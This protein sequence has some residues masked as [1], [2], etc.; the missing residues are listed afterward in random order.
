MKLEKLGEPP[1]GVET[2]VAALPD[3]GN[4]AGIAMQHL[5]ST[6]EMVR[7]AE[8]VA[9]WP[10]Y[11]KHK[12]GH[13]VYS[14]AN[15]GFY[16]REGLGFIVFSGDFQP[17]EPIFLYELCEDVV[18]Y[19][20]ELGVGRVV[21]LGAAHTGSVAG[22]PR[23]FY[24]A[25]SDAM[26]SLAEDVEALPLE[27]GG[28]ITGFNGLLLGIAYEKGLDALCLL[29]EI[30]NPEIRQPKAAKQVLITLARI[31]GVE[32]RM[33]YSKLDEEYERIR[34]GLAFA[35]EYRRLQRT[36]WRNPAGVI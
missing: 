14:R 32:D 16:K 20:K 13:V 12:G 30:D 8:L 25:T 24:A 33:D 21:T 15:F 10:P 27:G 7:F 1:S 22:T 18:S 19:A 2:L 4:V 9:Y 34:A 36:L 28:Y 23:V 26:R 17:H 3:M 11:V 29:A 31:L 6:L 35:R 5:I